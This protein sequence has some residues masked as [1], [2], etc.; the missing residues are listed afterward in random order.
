MAASSILWPTLGLL[1]AASDLPQA[2]AQDYTID[3]THQDV[4]EL[5]GTILRG[6]GTLDGARI[7]G[8][9]LRDRCTTM[10][11]TA[12]GSTTIDWTKVKDWASRDEGGQRI[13]PIDD[14]NGAHQVGVPAEA[15]PEPIGDAGALVESGFSSLADGCQS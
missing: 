2:R 1:F 3:R 11:T 5:L 7:T 14:G 13:T 8:F 10:L 4:G 12:G 15:Q 6:V 9:E